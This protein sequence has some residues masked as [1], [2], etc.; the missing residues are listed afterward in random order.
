MLFD[1]SRL[2]KRDAISEDVFVTLLPF[3]RESVVIYFMTTFPLF[4]NLYERGHPPSLVFLAIK[5]R[6][7]RFFSPSGKFLPIVSRSPV[8]RSPLPTLCNLRRSAT[9]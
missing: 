8:V 3:A 9:K 4:G 7:V 5:K 2:V 6:K 1:A